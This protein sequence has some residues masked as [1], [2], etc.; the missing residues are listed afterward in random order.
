ME[1]E[2]LSRI[3]GDDQKPGGAVRA[4]R[5]PAGHARADG[6]ARTRIPDWAIAALRPVADGTSPVRAVTHPLGFTC[7]P[8][9]RAGLSGVCVH[10]WSPR[11]ARTEPT[12][13]PVHAHS[14]RL[15]SYAL[16]GTLEN[17][18]MRITEADGVPLG[19]AGTQAGAAVS[20]HGAVPADPAI[21]RLIEV[22]SR[23]DADELVPT[24]R[25]VRCQ[26]A[27]CQRIQPGDVYSMPAGAFHRTDVAPGGEA[28]TVA[29]G[30]MVPGITDCSL[31][32]P[33]STRHEVWRRGCDAGQTAAAARLV[34]DLLRGPSQRAA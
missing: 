24:R 18:L 31:G 7:L 15:T 34:L 23:G 3:L 33:D 32:P 30:T 14:W 25:L 4:G 28:V 17:R 6:R 12:T 2:Y 29:L 22:R 27:Q 13:S 19:A 20:C 21:R 10:L 5:G 9:E 8:M 1:H 11:V 26:A 16:F